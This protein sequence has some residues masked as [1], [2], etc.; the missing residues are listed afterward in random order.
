MATL[1]SG[2]RISVDVVNEEIARLATAWGGDRERG[3][4]EALDGLLGAERL[5]ALDLFDQYQLEQVVAVCQRS[6]TLSEAGR[7]LFNKSRLRKSEPNDADRLRKY[8]FRFGLDWGAVNG[9]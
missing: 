6:R 8:L 2:G 5:A 4:A 3:Q 9:N 1:S 7:L